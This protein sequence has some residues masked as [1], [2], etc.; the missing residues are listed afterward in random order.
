MQVGDGCHYAGSVNYVVYGVMLRL[1]HN[2]LK[3]QRSTLSSTYSEE[4]MTLYITIWKSLRGAPNLTASLRWAKA[5]YNGWPSGPTPP[6]ELPAC[7]KCRKPLTSRLT[8]RWLPLDRA[9]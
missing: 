9:I 5:G 1:C 7:A 3:N 6:P 4:Q 2:H 8:A